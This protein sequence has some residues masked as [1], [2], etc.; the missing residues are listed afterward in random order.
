MAKILLIYPKLGST[1][2]LIRDLPLSLLYVAV[3]SIKAGFDVKIIDL[4]FREKAWE[5]LIRQELT[6]D[7]ILV[8]ISVMTGSPIKCALEVTELVK[9]KDRSIPVVWGGPHPTVEPDTTL[10]NENIDFLI[11]GYG[12]ESLCSLAAELRNSTS[13]LSAIEGLSYRSEGEIRHNPIKCNHEI[14][15]HADIPY[16]LIDIDW[17]KF[18]RFDGEERIFPVF[19]S[20]GCNYNCGFCISPTIYSKMQKRWV[21]Y[22]IE[23]VVS[24]IE[25]VMEKYGASYISFYDDD[26]FHDLDRMRELFEEIKKKQPGLTMGFRG[27]RINEIDK[28]DTSFLELMQEAGVRHMQIGVESGSPKILKLMHKGIN[29]EQIIRVNKKL[30]Q[31]PKLRPLYNIMAGVPGETLEDLKMTKDLMLIL[32]K[33]NPYCLTGA[34]ADFKP[35]PGSEFFQSSLEHGLQPPQTLEQWSEYDTFDTYISHPWYEKSF[36]S[37][38]N[39]MQVTSYFID[40]KITKEIISK[41]LAYR[42]ARLAARLYKPIALFRL[43]KNITGF[44]V[45]YKL[46]GL[47]FFILRRKKQ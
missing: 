18:S 17:N 8:G 20:L 5:D 25:F 42:L 39:M 29:V 45:E 19:T 15:A 3:D 36:K 22:K 1:D 40:D 33:D 14:P 11:K 31:F 9:M 38:I 34:V 10:K 28:M 32:I 7:T 12:S 46:M 35:I 23:D 4:R 13:N 41:R 27:A 26:S 37:Y 30:S 47:F 2:A 21:T 6:E 24:H 43:K 44:L 16:H